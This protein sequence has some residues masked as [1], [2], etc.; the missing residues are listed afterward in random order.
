MHTYVNT[1]T[2][3]M[4][5]HIIM[6]THTHTHTHTGAHGEKAGLWSSYVKITGDIADMLL[7]ISHLNLPFKTAI[8][9]GIKDF[10]NM[11]FSARCTKSP[12]QKHLKGWIKRM[13]RITKYLSSF[14]FQ[15]Y[16]IQA[17][18]LP[19]IMANQFA[20]C[21]ALFLTVMLPYK[22]TTLNDSM[23]STNPL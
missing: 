9:D 10:L 20:G 11:F 15:W 17:E 22:V 3:P 7:E 16:T 5:T 6:R 4:H 2:M 21:L 23:L 13:V 19:L 18:Q 14:S 1:H 12:W 8:A